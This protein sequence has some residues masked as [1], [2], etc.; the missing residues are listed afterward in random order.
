MCDWDGGSRYGGLSDLG[1]GQMAREQTENFMN[2]CLCG[3][4]L[5]SFDLRKSLT[6]PH[7]GVR[8]EAEAGTVIDGECQVIDE[9]AQPQ[10]EDTST[11]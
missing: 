7:C 8:R 6:C 4:C 5:R 9:P 2:S 10:I 3:V 11:E 1:L